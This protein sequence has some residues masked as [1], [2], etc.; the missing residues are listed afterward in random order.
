MQKKWYV[1]HTLSGHENKVK[2]NLE[3]MVETMKLNEKIG[4]ILIPTEEVVEYK[5]GEKRIVPRKKFPGYILV[6]MEMDDNA[7]HA[8]RNTRGIT[9]VGGV[10]VKPP[11][12]R[13]DEV[14]QILGKAGVKTPPKIKKIFEKGEPIQVSTGPFTD[15]TGTI[16]EINE[17]RRKMKVLLSIFGR[18]TPVELDFEQVKKI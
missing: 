15:L 12:L 4:Q 6:Q 18:D 10:A 8:I 7:W 2:M 17:E 1:F 5:A 11:P 13:E 14:A 9:N 16:I 3:R